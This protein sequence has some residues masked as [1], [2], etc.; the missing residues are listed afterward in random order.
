VKIEPPGRQGRQDQRML[1]FLMKSKFPG[2]RWRRGG[3]NL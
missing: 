2:V 1:V 3:S